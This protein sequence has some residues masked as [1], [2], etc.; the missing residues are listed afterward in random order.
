LLELG[1]RVRIHESTARLGGVPV[2]LLAGNRAIADPAEEIE[3]LLRPGFESGRLHVE[4]D[5]TL[6]GNVFAPNLLA[7]HAAVLVAVGLWK[8][9]SLGAAEGVVGGLD[10]LEAG[11]APVPKRVAVLAG[12][13]SAMDVCVAL[14]ARGAAEIYVVYGGPRAALHWHMSEGWFANP[15]VHAMMNWQPLRYNAD[16]AGKLHSVQLRH[17]EFETEVALP[18]NLVVEAMG[19]EADPGLLSGA[20]VDS[21]R[22]YTAGALV[23]GGASVGLCVAE[24]LA[25][26]DLIHESLLP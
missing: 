2:R 8:E 18:V 11:G 17:T 1:H 13:D 21:P 23:N 25:V 5:K 26:A 3:A 7:A 16:S 4:F 12:G 9:R 14:R 6:G 10:F 24:G 15:G 20:C 19:L 22:L